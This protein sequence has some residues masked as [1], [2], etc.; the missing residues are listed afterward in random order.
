LLLTETVHGATG[1][2]GYLQYSLISIPPANA[3]RLEVAPLLSSNVTSGTAWFDDIS[4][5]DLDE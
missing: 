3:V 2:T 1:T 4:V 5:V